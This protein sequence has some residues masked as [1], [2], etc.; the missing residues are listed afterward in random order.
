MGHP[1]G[2]A[3]RVA[4]LALALVPV[5]APARAANP[6][7][8]PHECTLQEDRSLL[9]ASSRLTAHL[10]L[11]ARR[12][13]LGPLLDT[14]HLTI[15]LVD[16][17]QG[18][19]Y[20]YAG[21][22]DQTMLYAASLPKIAILLAVMRAVAEGRLP[23]SLEL[24]I[25]LKLMVTV[26]SN[27]QATWAAQQVG[28][29]DI[30]QTMEDRAFCLYDRVHGGLWMG[31]PYAATGEALRDPLKGL[32]HAATA[33]QV[34]RFYARLHA[35]RLLSPF[36]SQRMVELM[37]PPLLPHKFVRGLASQTGVVFV[38]RKSGS[39]GNF[40]SDSAIIEHY[41]KRYVLVGLSEVAD[42]FAALETLART[43]DALIVTGDHRARPLTANPNR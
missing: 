40:H 34:A 6:I 24:A 4:A 31:K 1:L 25:R 3:C 32:S 41:G 29:A 19:P 28:L 30:A 18:P 9:S 8:S 26:S 38:A 7:L 33:L 17:T 5:Q 35:G 43:V 39:W 27:E 42:D 15:A 10:I 11:A 12:A 22:N 14:Q 37:A 2:L 23:W 21:I 13:G 16:L 36:W 20:P